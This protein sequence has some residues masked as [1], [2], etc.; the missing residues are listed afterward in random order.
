M[1]TQK[2]DTK[3]YVGSL[4]RAE[5]VRCRAAFVRPRQK[6]SYAE[7]APVLSDSAKGSEVSVQRRFL[8]RS[9]IAESQRFGERSTRFHRAQ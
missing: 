1:Q 4:N 5:G 8:F 3:K 7:V 2:P 6:S 9:V